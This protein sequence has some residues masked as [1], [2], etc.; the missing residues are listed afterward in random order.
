MFAK[1][2]HKV[3]CSL[4]TLYNSVFRSFVICQ[5]DAAQVICVVKK[6]LS[7]NAINKMIR[8]LE[9]LFLICEDSKKISY[10]CKQPHAHGCTST[11]WRF[12][13]VLLCFILIFFVFSLY[14]HKEQFRVQNRKKKPAQQAE[15]P[16]RRPRHNKKTSAINP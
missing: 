3:R 10:A 2:N 11:F 4:F 15:R 6:L 7:S 8:W 13:A 16:K 1:K 12:D 5:N 9:H 14:L